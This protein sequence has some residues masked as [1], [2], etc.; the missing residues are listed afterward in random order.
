VAFWGTCLEF[1]YDA[2]PIQSIFFC[3][4]ASEELKGLHPVFKIAEFTLEIT[5]IYL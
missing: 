5:I 2:V 3:R 4:F 1:S